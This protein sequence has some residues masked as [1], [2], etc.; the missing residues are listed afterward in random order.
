MLSLLLDENLSN[1]IA[2][3]VTAKRSDISIFSAHD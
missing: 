3:Q 2:Q 1:E